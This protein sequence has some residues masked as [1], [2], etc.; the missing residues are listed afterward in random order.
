MM[1]EAISAN[2][3]D[4]M[5]SRPIAEAKKDGTEYL[6]WSRDQWHIGSWEQQAVFDHSQW[7]ARQVPG[8]LIRPHTDD[9]YEWSSI[10]PT[11]FRE[12]PP[13]VTES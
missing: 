7:P 3:E 4:A 11:H 6:L 9:P 1:A 13:P 5:S 12:L 8:W 10:E 2:R